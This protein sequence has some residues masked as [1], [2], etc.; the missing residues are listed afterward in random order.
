M[1]PHDPIEPEGLFDG[2]RLVPILLGALI[3]HLA[4]LL[5]S[6][7][8]LGAVAP[9]IASG[10][11]TQETADRLSASLPFLLGT[12]LIGALCTVFAAFLGARMAGRLFVSHGGWIAVTGTLFSLVYLIP[13]PDPAAASGPEIALPLWIEALAWL[14][15]LPAGIAGGLLARAVSGG[16]SDPP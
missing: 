8:L 16:A 2:L 3:D 4:T 14:L 9:E 6:G 5:A 10:T 1:E 11:L 7:L 13:G 12:L 15:I